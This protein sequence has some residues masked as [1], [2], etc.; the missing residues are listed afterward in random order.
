WF[1]SQDEF[2]RALEVLNSE[3][4]RRDAADPIQHA[5]ADALQGRLL[6]EL[7]QT[8]EF[9]RWARECG[10]EARKY[11]D[12][13]IALGIHFFDQQQIKASAAALMEG[14]YLDPTDDDGCHR[15]ARVWVALGHDN[16]A[17]LMR[18]HAIRVATLKNL[19]RQL[20]LTQ[21]QPELTAELPE[22]LISIAR[23][24]EAIGWALID[25]GPG[26]EIK[27]SA[28]LKQLAKLRQ[29][30]QVIGMSSEY[31]MMDMTRTAYPSKDV[32]KQLPE[33]KGGDLKS[34]QLTV[35]PVTQGVQRSSAPSFVNVASD[36]GLGF[37]WYP[38]P[39]ANLASIPMHEMM[40][41]GIAVCD[42]DLDGKPDIYF[43]QGS[44]EPPDVK[45][46]R[47]NQLNRNIGKRFVDVTELSG[48]GD[49]GYSSG[50]A[51][52][53]INQ[54]GFPDLYIGCLGHNRLLINN[55]D[56]TYRDATLSLGAVSPQ[57]TSSVA[58]ADLTG[59]G[60]PE[61]FECVYV[62][63]GDGFRLPDRNAAGEE[64]PPNPNDFYAEADRWYLSRGD[65]RLD[66]Q[67]LDRQAIQPGTALGLVVTDIDGDG[68][69]DVFVAN[70]ARPNHL[71]MKFA[72][73][74]V[75]NVADLVGLGY[76]FRGFSNSCMG[77]A[78]GDFNRDGR[79]DLHI[80]NFLN[81]SNNL[82]L[83]GKGGLFSDYATRFRLNPLC[84][85]YTGFGIKKID[86]D[87]NGWPDFVVTNGHV[88]DQSSDGTDFQMYPQVLVNEGTQFRASEKLADYFGHQYVGRSMATIDF[89]S[90]QDL[91]LV[92]GHLDSPI[93]LLENQTVK[94][95]SCLQIELIGT[96]TEREGTGCRVV[97]NFGGQLFTDWMVA[98]DGYLS[99]DEAVLDFGIGDA[100]GVGTV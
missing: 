69:N 52:G 87:R 26:N 63:M 40:G 97:V 36:L 12:Y 51:A 98:G 95:N 77:I 42:F 75:S 13:W 21:P 67:V 92:V 48:T 30:P 99:S 35:D 11:S 34:S 91:D 94:I 15:L 20:S 22:Q 38:N 19:V 41:G 50:I 10:P 31:A 82:F 70:D 49:F 32:L 14:V 100:R 45:G 85:P 68:A 43:A 84:E 25:L 81:E 66:L 23:P 39:D 59:D 44:G 4:R 72:S 24:F 73:G 53:D 17:A 71:L 65:G 58:I 96:Q 78:T 5:A 33:L 83:Q 61:L 54:D 88:F 9:V 18:E 16:A 60:L 62:E 79:F 28:L 2:S 8:N 57:F 86:L 55:G 64:L 3:I 80:T 37:Q 74:Q 1:F 46:A 29:D 56:G 76:G 6:A 90:D 27:R 89:D 47:S 7:Q 93:A